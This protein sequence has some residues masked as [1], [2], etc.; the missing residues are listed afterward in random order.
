MITPQQ[1]FGAKSNKEKYDILVGVAFEIRDLL[2]ELKEEKKLPETVLTH[3]EFKSGPRSR[4]KR[5]NS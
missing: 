1:Y 5:K 2:V 4:H 3:K